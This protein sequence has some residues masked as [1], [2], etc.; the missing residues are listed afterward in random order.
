MFQ[1]V[2]T[3]KIRSAKKHDHRKLEI[4]SLN[5]NVETKNNEEI[6]M[7]SAPKVDLITSE[8]ELL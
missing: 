5:V 7:S 4:E 1:D 3:S 2:F 8:W 6:S